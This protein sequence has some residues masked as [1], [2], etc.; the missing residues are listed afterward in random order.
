MVG[1]VLMQDQIH[2]KNLI[3]LLKEHELLFG[4]GRI[5]FGISTES[6]IELYIW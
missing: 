2:G 4:M 6:G 1:W 3:K 5:S